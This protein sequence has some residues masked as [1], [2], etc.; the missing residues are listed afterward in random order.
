MTP[1]SR[2]PDVA[3]LA[4]EAREVLS[5][6]D[7]GG[8]TVPTE[9]LYPFQWN[10]DS[11]FVAMGFAVFDVD[12]A[13]R[14]LEM[15]VLGQWSDGMIPHIVFHAPAETYFPGPDVWGTA[16][17]P[18][19]SGISQ[20][21]VLGTALRAVSERADAGHRDRIVRLFRSAL[22]SHRWW[23]AARDPEGSG[24]V[25]ILH[26][27][28]SGR[29]NAPCW[30]GALARVPESTS[31]PVRRRDTGHVEASMRPSDAE[32]RRYIH[33]VD[34]YRDVGWDP[35]RMWAAAPFRVADVGLNAILLRAEED[36]LALADRFG[37]PGDAAEIAGRAGRL[38]EALRGCWDE[39]LGCFVSVDLVSG[40][41]IR[42]ASSGGFLPVATGAPTD[43]Q[44][45]AMADRVA[46]WRARGLLAVP[47]APPED[48]GFDSRR[49][50]RG[51]VWPVVN[52]LIA[53]GFARH[54][55]SEVAAAV[56]ADTLEAISAGGMRE[57]FDPLTREA[58][59]GPSFSWT[60]AAVLARLIPSNAA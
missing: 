18:P 48:P 10:W 37:G 57:Y 9:G 28:E 19:T 35:A 40:E 20:P 7:R 14:E 11:A 13:L 34:A 3:E 27:W 33:L 21:P 16:H 43:A 60:A 51:P 44:V 45:A 1:P 22:A 31:T 12:R 58:L 23:A 53:D 38:A 36:L 32:Y 2:S 24:L 15:L 30:D 4:A 6:N 59:G 54:G 52:W 42:S 55:R 17:D 29:D 49:Y 47:S 46:D 25:A 8:Y 56:D 41:R 50:W 39:A 5:R 26:P